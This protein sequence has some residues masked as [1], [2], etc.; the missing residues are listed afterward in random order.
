MYK[1]V[2]VAY[3]GTAASRSALSEVLRIV[4]APLAEVHLAGVVHFP[5]EYMRGGDCARGVVRAGALAQEEMK[6]SLR[7]A[8]EYLVDKGLNVTDHLLVGE[9]VDVLSDLADQLRIDVVIL[10]HLRP[11]SFA[12]RW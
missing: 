2:L 11:T 12:M 1:K 6:G 7:E 8:H 9:P 10:G 5:S 4:S 3:D